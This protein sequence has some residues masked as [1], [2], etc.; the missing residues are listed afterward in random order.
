MSFTYDASTDAGKVR[1]L[2]IDT[3][4]TYAAFADAEIQAFLDLC[5]GSVRLAAAM[6]LDQIASNQVLRM[7]K[8][9]MLDLQT[10][11][12]AM[13]RELRENAKALR[14]AEMNESGFQIA[15]MVTEQFGYRER[16]QKQF[17]RGVLG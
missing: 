6:A 7:K 16:W 8:I 12:P 1:L 5:D 15:E 10:D 4:A 9:T 14:N 2:A 3:D 13:G 17:D 11:G